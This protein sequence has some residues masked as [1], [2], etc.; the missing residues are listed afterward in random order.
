LER[1]QAL[2]GQVLR[3]KW[4]LDGLI[5]VG[6]MASVFAATHRNGRRGAVKLLHTEFSL[7]KA[8]RSRFLR[9]GY[10]ANKVGHPGTV[11]ILDDDVADEGAVFLVME[12]LEG[13]SVDRRWIRNDRRLD[14]REVLL[15]VDKV[16]DVLAAAHE[17]GI[18]H[19]DVKPENI[20]VTRDGTVKML[21]FGIARLREVSSHSSTATRFGTTLGTPAFMSPE[22][23]LGRNDEVDAVSDLWAVGA[24]MF[25]LI[26]GRHVHGGKT[27]NEQLVS[28]ATRCAP[29]VAS[30]DDDVP[31]RIAAIV[32]KA[33]SFEKQGRYPD[34]RTMQR[35]VREAYYGLYGRSV[36]T[37]PALEVPDAGYPDLLEEMRTQQVDNSSIV[38]TTMKPATASR[39]P[40]LPRSRF[41][42][43]QLWV[44]AALSLL[45]GGA[46][47]ISGWRS[48]VHRAPAASATLASW[49]LH[50][51]A[52]EGLPA[53]PPAP[54]ASSS[55]APQQPGTL[56]VSSEGA[57]C[58][59]MVD[60]APRG[61]TPS[62]V[63]VAPGE[64][65]V[66]CTPRDGAAQTMS[67]QVASGDSSKAVFQFR[68]T[69][70]RQPA[71]VA[72]VTPSAATAPPAA[73]APPP[74]APTA[75][76][77]DPRDRRK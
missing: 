61:T 37:A 16:L 34:A 1:A 11:E 73:S 19:R 77:Q 55:P 3:D 20:F 71:A 46:I 38:Q 6:G 27:V 41:R 43:W 66:V 9:E 30:V 64:H 75:S 25:T 56:V 10:L 33:L 36:A 2:V 62:T 67:V 60:G 48:F 68:K 65:Q 28:A 29:S 72:P 53:A 42:A 52:A 63:T 15:I 13:E 49:P 40:S 24:S 51:I 22:Q 69:D 57:A 45:L 8:I 26:T 59:V 17:K 12:L 74:P 76:A 47:A 54:S 23:A 39:S 7:D 50:S 21:D 31:E 35:D 32:D 4:H 44:V 58:S 14:P 18:V 70:P 5:G